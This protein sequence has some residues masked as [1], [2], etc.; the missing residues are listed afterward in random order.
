MEAGVQDFREA[1]ID[2]GHARS[3]CDVAH[4]MF[5]NELFFLVHVTSD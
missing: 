3:A 4:V 2:V 5:V 1:S